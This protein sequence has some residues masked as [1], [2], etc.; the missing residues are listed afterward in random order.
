MLT[1][2]EVL[3]WTLGD[4]NVSNMSCSVALNTPLLVMG[5]IWV[6]G[7]VW[8]SGRLNISVPSN[9]ATNLKLLY[10]YSL[11]KVRGEESPNKAS[12]RS[13]HVLV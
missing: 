7:P 13:G 4:H 3:A 11:L 1:T 10:K 5:T 2:K 9:F 6:V 8:E 12:R